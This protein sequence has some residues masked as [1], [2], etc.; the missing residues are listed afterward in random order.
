MQLNSIE[1]VLLDIKQKI[2]SSCVDS[3]H[4]ITF[5]ELFER[6]HER[7]TKIYCRNIKND[8][9]FWQTH[10]Q[11]WKD[12]KVTDISRFTVQD[13]VDEYNLTSFS[14]ATRA[15]NI[16]SA[17]I[18]WGI[19][20]GYV[21]C[22]NPC[23][24]IEKKSPRARDRFLQPAELV[25]FMLALQSE[26]QI[27]K[28]LFSIA[29]LTGAR[30]GRVLAMRWDEIDFSLGTWRFENKN[31]DIQY[32]PLVPEALEI[33]SARKSKS[34]SDWVF[35]GRWG[36]DHMVDPV[37]PFKRV[38]Q[39]AG[40][41]NLR[42]H[43]LRRTAGSYLAIQGESAYI[44]GQF[45]GHKDQRSTA[46]YA[47]LN[48][49]PVRNAASKMA[50]NWSKLAALPESDH[51]STIQILEYGS[52][53]GARNDIEKPKNANIT[54]SASDQVIIEGKILITLRQGHSTKKEMYKRIGSRPVVIN[55]FELER[56]L[57]EM[58]ERGL[59]YKYRDEKN[60]Q[61]F[62]YSLVRDSFERNISRGIAE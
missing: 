26:P 51:I 50:K 10:G 49:E 1:Q 58:I 62:R 32:T 31:G 5:G 39:R 60:W 59:I 13:W 20:R 8:V 3:S 23:K 7:H 29:L 35:P 41:S 61:Y 15:V 56:I 44:I 38:L 12:T 43:D 22:V 17:V 34:F 6:Y 55:A 21:T 2:E 30:K 11:R 52:G 19:K 25:R 47:R 53:T 16:M 45:L 9:Y 24:G 46:I 27:F 40:I 33:L 42:F 48:L 57:N 36:K 54:M 4:C 18:N 14:S 28:D 37:K